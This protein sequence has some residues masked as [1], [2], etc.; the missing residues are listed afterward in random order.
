MI[1]A[2]SPISMK[3]GQNEGNTKKTSHRQ[4]GFALR[5]F[6]RY[7]AHSPRFWGQNPQNWTKISS[8][9]RKPSWPQNTNSFIIIIP[10]GS[11]ASVACHSSFKSNRLTGASQELSTPTHVTQGFAVMRYRSCLFWSKYSKSP[12]FFRKANYIIITKH[13]F[14]DKNKTKIY[15][16]CS[17]TVSTAVERTRTATMSKKKRSTNQ[18]KK[19]PYRIRFY[20]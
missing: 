11:L 6:L 16:I 15:G 10:R 18:R 5:F 13:P 14:S 8:E 2:I 3:L 4:S 20:A 19:T 12:T 17:S 7:L 1:Q 9:I